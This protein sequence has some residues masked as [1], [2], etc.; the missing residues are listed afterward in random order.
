MM[1]CQIL[2]NVLSGDNML[3][4]YLGHW[5]MKV[6]G[7]LMGKDKCWGQEADPSR[8][9]SF[10]DNAGVPTIMKEQA[11]IANYHYRI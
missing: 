5:E 10:H 3:Y 11:D 7:A 2:D 1:R 6:D 9:T 8:P 4:Y